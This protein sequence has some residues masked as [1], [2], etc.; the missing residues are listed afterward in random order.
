MGERCNQSLKWILSSIYARYKTETSELK[1]ELD[2]L[3][4]KYDKIS[5]KV[6]TP[7][8]HPISAR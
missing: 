8:F 3:M 7:H 5:T 4:D 1:S 6:V 2:K